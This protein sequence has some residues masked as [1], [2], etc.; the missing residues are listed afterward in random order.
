MNPCCDVT[1]TNILRHAN[2]GCFF[3]HTGYEICY[4]IYITKGTLSGY[5]MLLPYRA[6]CLSSYILL[7]LILWTFAGHA[8]RVNE[9]RPAD[10]LK[11]KNFSPVAVH[12]VP[13]TWPV[14]FLLLVLLFII[15]AL[16][17]GIF[18]ILF[19]I[20][21]V[22]IRKPFLLVLLERIAIK[23]GNQLMEAN[24]FLIRVALGNWGRSSPSA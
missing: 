10:D 11:K 21:L 15:K 20:L 16:L 5:T 4:K 1:W 2:T 7:S 17:Y 9:K 23:V 19:A 14:L 18:I 13:L 24:T 22:A 12:F 8:Y 6:Y 3:L